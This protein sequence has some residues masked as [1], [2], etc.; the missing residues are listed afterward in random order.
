MEKAR[1]RTISKNEVYMDF[2]V[3]RELNRSIFLSL[4]PALSTPLKTT[5]E[6][7]VSSTDKK[8]ERRK[9]TKI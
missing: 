4:S 7:F 1:G 5:V 6:E 9:A 2:Q 8:K 3:K